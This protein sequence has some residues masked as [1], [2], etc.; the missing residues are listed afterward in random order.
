MTAPLAFAIVGPGAIARE[1]A[2]ALRA[3]R[4]GS[5]ALGRPPADDR[6]DRRR[7]AEGAPP[8]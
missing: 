2:T 3:S 5:V 4:A 8:R 1:F 7:T 6:E